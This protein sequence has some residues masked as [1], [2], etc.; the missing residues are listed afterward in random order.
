MNR[1]D[2]QS[3]ANSLMVQHGLTAQGWRFA[4]D[5]AR[6]RFGACDYRRKEIRLSAVMTPHVSDSHVMNTILH[7]IAHAL[8]GIGAGHNH[9]WRAKALEIG[10]N[11]KRCG[12]ERVDIATRYI[13]VCPECKTE[14]KR[15]R[16][17]R[18]ARPIC[19]RRCH[20]ARR[21]YIP[22]EWKVNSAAA[23]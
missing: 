17:P 6:R 5:H 2:A 1:V 14:V 13:G 3:L 20:L 21:V 7:E 11:G 16:R 8:V 4:W 23:A 19:C 22:F 10:C 9:V 12:T 15:H 18:N